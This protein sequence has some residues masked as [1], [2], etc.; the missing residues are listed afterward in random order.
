MDRPRAV[1]VGLAGVEPS[2][3]ELHLLRDL[4]PL[5]VILFRRN[6]VDA[7]QLRNLTAAI[8]DSL[9]RDDA[10]VLVDQEGG[11]VVRLPPPG[12]RSYPAARRIGELA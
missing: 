12:W 3:Q 10:P 6:V 5:G 7:A 4:D 8:R 1:V 9:G 2:Q 11:R